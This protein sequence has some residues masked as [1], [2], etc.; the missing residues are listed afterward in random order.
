M[1]VFT[2]ALEALQMDAL[3]LDEVGDDGI[4][5]AARRLAC[6]HTG[7]HVYRGGTTWPAAHGI[8]RTGVTN[9][10]AGP[11]HAACGD[12]RVCMRRSR[13]RNRTPAW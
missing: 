9:M 3:E 12:R 11:V 8:P 1:I 7:A 4:Y 2:D 6:A 10:T 5:L 13:S